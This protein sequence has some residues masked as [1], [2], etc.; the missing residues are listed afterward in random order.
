MNWQQFFNLYRHYSKSLHL[1][2]GSWT[3]LKLKSCSDP[4]RRENVQKKCKK[5]VVHGKVFL[6]CLSLTA[7]FT[8]FGEMSS[9]LILFFVHC[10][11]C[12]YLYFSLGCDTEFKTHNRNKISFQKQPRMTRTWKNNGLIRLCSFQWIQKQSFVPMNPFWRI[13]WIWNPKTR[14]N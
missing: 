2:K 13:P 10:I 7:L 3:L 11:L 6:F 12:I 1:V 4:P 5:S 14:R 9:F 8:P